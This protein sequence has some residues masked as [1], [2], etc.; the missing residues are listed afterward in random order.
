[1]EKM[2]NFHVPLAD[3]TYM[4]LRKEAEQLGRPATELARTAIEEWL[5]QRRRQ[6]L[7]EAIASYASRNAGKADLDEDLERAGVEALLDEEA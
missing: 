6:A 3:S 4:K 5:R 7:H 1:M 2:R